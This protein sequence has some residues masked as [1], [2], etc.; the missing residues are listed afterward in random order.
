M[1]AGIPYHWKR[2]GTDPSGA[3]L[4]DK[5]TGVWPSYVASAV[6]TWNGG[7]STV[8]FFRYTGSDCGVIPDGYATVCNADYTDSCG[9]FLDWVGCVDP[10]GVTQTGHWVRAHVRFDDFVAG[11]TWT[12]AKHREVTCHELGHVLGLLHNSSSCLE[13]VVTGN[14]TAPNA[15][16]YEQANANHNHTDC[17][18]PCPSRPEGEEAV[19]RGTPIP[20]RVFDLLLRDLGTPEF[21]VEQLYSHHASSIN[22]ESNHHE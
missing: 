19:L 20:I 8:D 2:Y 4:L 10:L 16:D 15:H 11:F 18:P 22:H 9:G 5:T 13:E 6:S 17:V 1:S 12:D 3:L 21:L 14:F 7:T